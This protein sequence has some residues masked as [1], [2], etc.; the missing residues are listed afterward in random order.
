MKDNLNFSH[1]TND[2]EI[3]KALNGLK[4]TTPTQVQSQ[5]IPPMK[6]GLDITVQAPTGTGK[7]IAFALPT[8]ELIDPTSRNIEALVLSPTRE[9]AMQTASVL[10][11][12][13]T[14]KPQVKVAT[15]YGGEPIEKQFAAL[16]R[17]PSIVVATPGRLI[18]H[19]N[20]KSIKLENLKILVL[21]EAD[22]ML[23]MGFRPDLDR[24]LTGLTSERQTGLFSAT[25]SPAILKIAK[26]YQKDSQIIKVEQETLT[27]DTVEEYFIK[28]QRGQKVD[29]LMALFRKE[30][31]EKALVFS[32]TIR[33]TETLVRVLKNNMYN[34]DFLHGDMS[35]G[36]RNRVLRK[37]KSGKIDVLVATDV[38]ARGIDVDDINV[39]V[40]FDVPREIESY[41]HR[42]GRTGRAGE[43]GEAFTFVYKNEIPLVYEIM[44]HTEAKIKEIPPFMPREKKKQEQKDTKKRPSNKKD[45]RS[46]GKQRSDDKDNFKRKDGKSFN[47]KSKDNDNFK[48]D[49]QEGNR[50]Q[51][52]KP[53]GKYQGGKPKGKYQGSRKPYSGGKP[54]NKGGYKGYNKSQGE[55]KSQG[56]DSYQDRKPKEGNRYQGGKPKG[57]YQGSK[58]P[59]SGGKPQNKGGYKGYSKS[60]GDDKSQSSDSYQDRKPKEGNR[61]QGGKPKGKYQGSRKPYSGGKPQNKD[62]YK[63]YNKSQSDDKS[64]NSDS[65]QDRK[66]KEGNRYQ[67]GKPKGKYQGSRK[68]YS[69]GKPQNKGGYKGKD[70]SQN[71]NKPKNRKP[72]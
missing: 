64:Q 47:R 68:P 30:H 19:L 9:L 43:E 37:F 8:I 40:N 50:Y 45:S 66:P 24:I 32:N 48:E 18:D 33:M 38:A 3:L 28:L 69:G 20:R 44:A 39:V 22:R 29:E 42:I 23:D 54:Q 59:Y 31:P 72:R 61:Y 34:A 57:K 10:R 26:S 5:A 65:Y 21:D 67:G 13:A 52:G 4:I 36:S 2:E 16:R 12:L 7:T 63:G 1:L 35:Q 71:S 25:L 6:Q 46:K 70:K 53:K 56:S 55:D 62:G 60:Q 27:V 49:R 15:I 11:Q 41:V 51:G 14:Y 58:K 17:K